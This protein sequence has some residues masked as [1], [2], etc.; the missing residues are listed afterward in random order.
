MN[1]QAKLKADNEASQREN[2]SRDLISSPFYSPR[3]GSGRRPKE[4]K[5]LFRK[6]IFLNYESYLRDC[7]F[8]FRLSW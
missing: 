8:F 2:L 4:R 6:H 5:F 7:F 3:H 1:L